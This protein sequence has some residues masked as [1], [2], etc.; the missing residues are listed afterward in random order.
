[1]GC[2]AFIESWWQSHILG[3]ATLAVT[4]TYSHNS[5]LNF[6]PVFLASSS[7]ILILGDSNPNRPHRS[8]PSPV[9]LSTLRLRLQRADYYLY[10][11]NE[12]RSCPLGPTSER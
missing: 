1:M 7:R 2:A 3:D 11:E 6:L 8:P 5:R 9:L 12:G 10:A 4:A